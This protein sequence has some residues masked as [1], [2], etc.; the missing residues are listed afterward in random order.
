[1]SPCASAWVSIVAGMMWWTS[2]HS[3]VRSGAIK[4]PRRACA[5][6]TP[7]RRKRPPAEAI[8]QIGAEQFAENACD[9]SRMP[10]PPW[11][12]IAPRGTRHSGF[13]PTLSLLSGDFRAST[14]VRGC[15]FK[16][17]GGAQHGGFLERLADELDRY[18]QAAV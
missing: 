12:A 7:L 11:H 2:P 14:A 15:L 6:V 4:R 10:F 5:A 8:P 9:E 16:R 3:Y 1:M 18:R 17:V 13:P